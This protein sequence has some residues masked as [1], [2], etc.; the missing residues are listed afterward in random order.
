MLFGRAIDGADRSLGGCALPAAAVPMYQ[1]E[2]MGACRSTCT[3][4]SPFPPPSHGLSDCICSA[5]WMPHCFSSQA[6][7]LLLLQG[8][9]SHI[10]ILSLCY[11]DKLRSHFQIPGTAANPVN[12]SPVAGWT[13]FLLSALLVPHCK[14]RIPD[15]PILAVTE[16]SESFHVLRLGLFK[17]TSSPGQRGASECTVDLEGGSH[18]VPSWVQILIWT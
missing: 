13:E 11:L 2:A 17:D 18:C 16:P 12:T 4:P 1:Q 14:G 10:L 6:V 15:G 7:L 3:C 5:K 8:M 9:G